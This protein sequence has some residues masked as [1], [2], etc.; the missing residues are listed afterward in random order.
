MYKSVYKGL[1][2][3]QSNSGNRYYGETFTGNYTVTN[4]EMKL[5]NR[6]KGATETYAIQFEAVRG[7]RI[8]YIYRESVEELHLFKMK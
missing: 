3:T 6:F 5:T 1:D 2:N 8:L 7:G 4:W